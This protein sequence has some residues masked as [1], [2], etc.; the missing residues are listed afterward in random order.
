MLEVVDDR[1]VRVALAT[2]PRRIVSLVPSTTETLHDLGVGERVVGRTRFCVHPREALARL[3]VVGGTKDPDP[4]RI[5]ALAPDLIVANCEENRREDLD[6]LAQ[7]A[8]VYAAFPR[9]VDDA[10][11]DLLRLGALVDADEAARAWHARTEAALQ[12]LA[13]AAARTGRRRVAYLI[14]RDPWM[15]AGRD[16]YVHDLLAAVGFDNALAGLDGRYPT[17]EAGA[18]A[19]ADPDLVLLSSEPFPFRARHADELAAATGLPR[20]RFRRVD[21]ETFTWH[22]TRLA[23]TLPALLAALP[24]LEPVPA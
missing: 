1:G 10:L 16:T 13:A 7:V 18:L 24:H 22:G 6:A 23:R 21:G 5:R 19:S 2:P 8:P 20:D 4:L 11:R 15:A 17:V 9:T 12:A 3:A 14:W